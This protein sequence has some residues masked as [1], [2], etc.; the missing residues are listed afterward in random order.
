MGAGGEAPWKNTS[1]SG[2]TLQRAD[3]F[4]FESR[5]PEPLFSPKGAAVPGPR[6]KTSGESISTI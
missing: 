5:N 2:F 3:A 1:G 4:R 6:I